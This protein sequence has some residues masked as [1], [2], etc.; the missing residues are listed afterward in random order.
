[1]TLAAATADDFT[2]TVRIYEAA[3]ARPK[4]TVLANP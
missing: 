1:L 4:L 2:R 3:G